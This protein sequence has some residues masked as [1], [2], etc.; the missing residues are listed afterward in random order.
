MENKARKYGLQDSNN[1]Y[2]PQHKMTKAKLS[3]ALDMI[4]MGYKKN[5]IADKLGVD[6]KTLW[7]YLNGK[8]LLPDD[9]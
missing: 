6:R 5:A 4:S 9:K 8:R 7:L 2:V 1:R 3:Q